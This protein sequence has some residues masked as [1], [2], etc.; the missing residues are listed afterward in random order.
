M[1]PELRLWGA[2]VST[3]HGDKAPIS[4]VNRPEAGNGPGYTQFSRAL[5]ELN[6]DAIC[7]NT[8][9]ARGCVE[10]AHLTLQDRLVKEFRLAGISSMA[11]ANALMLSFI[12]S[13]N[14]KF[15]KAPR[16]TDDAH[17]ALRPEEDLELILTWRELRKVTQNLLLHYERKLY[18]LLDTPDNRR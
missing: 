13:Y 8:P 5:Y 4:R 11:A 10:R 9:V 14:R 12:E 1:L 7:A 15:A 2:H 16:N 17:R 18:V 6:I 3:S